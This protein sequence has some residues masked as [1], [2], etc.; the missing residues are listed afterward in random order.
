MSIFIGFGIQGSSHL[1]EPAAQLSIL[2]P[3]W[4]G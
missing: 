3:A 1:L 4:D 2:F